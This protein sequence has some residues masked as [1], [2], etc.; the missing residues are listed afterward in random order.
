MS[1]RPRRRNAAARGPRRPTPLLATLVIA[2]APACAASSSFTPAH[3][4]AI[5]DSVHTTIVAWRDALNA[6]DFARAGTYYA[7]DTAFRWYEDGKLTYTSAQAIRD[8]MKAMAPGLSG[9]DVTLIDPKITALGP[10]SAIVTAEFTEK[11]TD[12]TQRT[13]GF[14]GA[15][16]LV[17]VHADSGWQFLIGHN[18]SLPPPADTARKA[19]D[20][21]GGVP[22]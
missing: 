16:S 4:A 22:R 8:T 13:V 3:R 9:F 2:V 21:R 15:L 5:V 10:G 12:T 14:A 17:V 7:N 6:R 20:R 18:S 11:I 1:A 19:L